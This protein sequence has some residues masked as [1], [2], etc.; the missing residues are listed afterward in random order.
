VWTRWTSIAAAAAVVVLAASG[1]TTAL[2]RGRA[3]TAP[4]APVLVAARPPAGMVRA[5]VRA[6]PAIAAD[7]LRIE[8]EYARTA[9]QLAAAVDGQHGALSPETAAVVRR[10]LRTIDVAI[11]EARSA[12]ERDPHNPALVE[13]LS[14][15]YQQKL[16]LLKRTAELPSEL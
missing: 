14:V 11:A 10:S 3:P 2:R 13:M 12:L 9:A 16:A 1:T 15:S 8:R 4:A 5:G 6:A 7:Y